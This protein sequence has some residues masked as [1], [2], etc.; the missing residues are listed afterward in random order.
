M[1]RVR[2]TMIAPRASV[3]DG[4]RRRRGFAAALLLALLLAV[5]LASPSYAQEPLSVNVTNVDLA[6]FPE[7]SAVV[8]IGGPAALTAGAL[9][10]SAFTVEVDG[11][12]VQ[13][14]GDPPHQH[15][16]GADGDPPSHRRIRQHEGR[17]GRGGTRSRP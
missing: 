2:D 1:F 13:A 11:A 8:Q 14:T 12:A 9:D 7:I 10:P 6:A 17:G 16:A 5:M 15:G 4:R 3:S